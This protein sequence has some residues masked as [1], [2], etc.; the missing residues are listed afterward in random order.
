MNII[1]PPPMLYKRP[2]RKSA[3]IIQQN[4]LKIIYTRQKKKIRFCFKK[5]GWQFKSFWSE[6]ATIMKLREKI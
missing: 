3:E 4:V 2:S 1:A 6:L 5:N